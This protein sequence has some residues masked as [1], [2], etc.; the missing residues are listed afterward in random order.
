[1]KAIQHS[2]V[3]VTEQRKQKRIWLQGLM[4]QSAGFDKGVRY[5]VDYDM[6][7]KQINLVIDKKG[8]RT[9]SGRKKGDSYDPIVDICNADITKLTQGITRVRVDVEKNCIVVSM[10]HF[11]SKQAEREHRLKEHIN[12]GYITEGSLC[13]GIGMATGAIHEG[14]EEKGLHSRVEWIV[15]RDR[16]YLQVA[17]DNNRALSSE[18]VLIEA[19]IEELEPELLKPVDLAQFSLPCSPHS[20]AGKAKNKLSNA[21][22]HEDATAV[23]GLINIILKINPALIVSENVVVSRD[24]AT[25][26]LIKAMLVQMGYQIHEMELDNQQSGSFEKRK[27]YWFIAMS[28][29]LDQ[30]DVA[31]I[32][33]FQK[34]YQTLSE[35]LEPVDDDD[36]MWSDN[37][38]L[39][40]KAVR[41]AE[42]GKGFA[43]RQ[44]V[45]SEAT[46]IGCIGRHYAKR[47]STEPFVTRADGKERLLTP[48]EHAHVKSAPECLIR[49]IAPTI[50]HQGLGQGIDWNQA[51]GIAYLIADQLLQNNNHQTME[52]SC[53]NEIGQ[54]ASEAVLPV[55]DNAVVDETQLLLF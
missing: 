37:Q 6:N 52:T 16:R 5:R 10:H 41:D 22:Q 32:P 1:M 25:Y 34:R 26:L 46:S 36:P 53:N 9:V 45:T 40:D 48:T 43:K 47:R 38:Y 55:M 12:Q 27:R 8:N 15:D 11:D 49:D 35:V 33:S 50:A 20:V 13:A 18:T 19:S 2:Y 30:V 7:S 3:A 24:S 17:H 23:F 28:S 51:K 4:L 21:E 29:T 42:D 39:K 31:K 54:E 44:L 14:F